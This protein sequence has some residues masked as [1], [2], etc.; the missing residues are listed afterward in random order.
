M[1]LK[2]QVFIVTGGGGG[3][4][5]AVTR[6]FAR[7]GAKMVIVER[8]LEH[9]QAVAAEVAG[10]ALA[11]DLTRPDDATRMVEEVRRSCSRL[12]GLIHTVGGFAMAPLG[13]ADLA[14][15]DRMFDIN[16]RSLFCALRATVP[17]LSA[18]KRGFVAAFSSEPALSGAQ[19]GKGLYAAAKSAVQMM[20]RTLDREL[21]GTE[22][23][24]AI[25]YPMGA[26]DTPMNRRDMPDFDPAGYIDPGEIAET[27]L[28]AATRG[29]R[30]RLAELP[31]WPARPPRR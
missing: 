23:K 24:V 20:M 31:V 28:F 9:A 29:P 18:Q 5:G 4:G 17:I 26:V 30:A 11:A 8:S 13:Q 7:A 27:L 16:V 6:T 25:V 1:S 14:Q 21:E 2:D 15:Y 3:I 12:D 10:L 22:V 19:A